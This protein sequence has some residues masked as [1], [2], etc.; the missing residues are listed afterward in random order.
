MLTLTKVL[1]AIMMGF[2]A[3]VV[4]GWFFIP[5]LKKINFKQRI[6]RYVGESHQKKSGTPTMGG[7][8]FIVPTVLTTIFLLAT[9]RIGFSYDLIIALFVFVAYAVLGFIDDYVSIRKGKNQGLTISQKFLGQALIAIVFFALFMKYNGDTRFVVSSL[10][11]NWDLKWF[12]GIFI[13]FLLV[14]FSNAVNLT[15]GLDGL[16]GDYRQ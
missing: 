7:L 9:K 15:D 12:Y 6:S 8:I 5:F 10:G 1:L 2:V 14:G 16:A 4:F 11:I 13:L 3:S